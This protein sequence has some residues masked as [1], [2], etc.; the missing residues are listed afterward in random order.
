MMTTPETPSP[1]EQ[2]DREA[3]HV[4]ERV[5]HVLSMVANYSDA[6]A[7]GGEF[8]D[9]HLADMQAM[10]G[11]VIAEDSRFLARHRLAERARLTTDRAV[12][13]EAK[14][15]GRNL[16]LL[17]GDNARMA[18]ALRQCR[19]QFAF[20]AR[21]HYAAGKSEKGDTNTRFA[22]IANG[23][24][25]AVKPAALSPP[26]PEQG[27]REALEALRAERA[28]PLQG[29]E[30]GAWDRGRRY[31]LDDAIRIVEALAATPPV[32]AISGVWRSMSTAP[33]DGT[34]IMLW[35]GQPWSCAEFGHWYEPWSNWQTDRH[36]APLETEEYSGIGAEVP[37]AWQP[38]PCALD[39]V[40]TISGE[41]EK[42]REAL[43]EARELILELSHARGCEYEGT[44][45][46]MIGF[47]DA[48]L[49]TPDA[50]PIG[51]AD[52]GAGA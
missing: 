34:R 41:G 21:E 19:D 48:A 1:V 38:E 4:M 24:L 44:D 22:D 6:V 42:L 14:A 40:P 50:A 52:A 5:Q 32:P 25:T 12:G 33:K 17:Q 26:I 13:A 39:P 10:N 28:K 35:L 16:Y 18:D 3:V 31:G 7:N 30:H 37:I 45:E 27:G 9:R 47:I 15:A 49:A 2:V 46:D 23:A 51:S 11:D 8:A 20:Y 43:I 29:P 36:F